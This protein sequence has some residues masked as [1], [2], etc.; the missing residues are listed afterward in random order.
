MRWLKPG[1]EEV[2]LVNDLCF[3]QVQA[4]RYKPWF[5]ED[6]PGNVLFVSVHGY[7]PRERGLEHMLPMAAFYPGSG[8]TTLPATGESA[9]AVV[10]EPEP[11]E[12]TPPRG[13]P[14]AESRGSC[15]GRAG[16]VVVIFYSYYF[17]FSFV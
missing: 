2:V 3:G 5:G 10:A 8:M 9:D 15:V 16:C 14:S 12:V 6:D 17:F 4:P 13:A 7:G 1:L 11:K